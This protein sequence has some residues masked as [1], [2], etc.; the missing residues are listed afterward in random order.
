MNQI[1]IALYNLIFIPL[2]FLTIFTL[3][4]F[5]P[6][7]RKGIAG[8][9]GTLKK[10][11]H[12]IHQLPNQNQRIWVHVS[13]YGEYL[14]AE[15]LLIALKKKT[16]NVIIIVTVFSP[17][18][19]ENIKIQPPVDYL[20]YLPFDTYFQVKRFTRLLSPSFAV[21]VRHDIWPNMVWRIKKENTPLF[22][23]DA[24]LPDKSL[25]F[26]PIFKTLNSFLL[27]QFTVIFVISVKQADKFERIGCSPEQLIVSGD[28]KY[29]QVYK[30]SRNV[31]KIS[32]LIKNPALQNKKTLVA[33]STWLTDELM[34]IPAFSQLHKKKENCLLIIAPHE[35]TDKR[36]LEIESLCQ[37][38]VLKAT[39]YSNLKNGDTDF[40]CLIIDKI[41]LLAKIYSLGTAA[42]VGGSF[43][44]K[45][46][47]VLE[48]AIHGVPVF[49][50]PK[51][52]ASAEANHLL[53]NNAAFIVRSE[54][55][56]EQLLLQLFNDPDFASDFGKKAKDIVTKNVGSAEKIAQILTQYL[57]SD[58]KHNN[59]P[60]PRGLYQK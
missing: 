15:P 23:I 55:D 47:N 26:I 42:F 51:V 8:R 40:Q 27:R 29:D 59:R 45:I 53:N 56:I 9:F 24:S 17:S 6:K 54:N 30:R 20:C 37:K 10:L 35:P 25:R 18:G 19:H 38:Y 3:S 28:T 12:F 41:G 50:G 39:R 57:V 43:K 2:S 36:I 7:V 44:T 13:S 46:H 58:R 11:K 31:G 22:L 60:H 4:L 52:E 16:P 33:G 1:L 34:I 48:P 32:E 5:N 49:F 21:I 14:Q